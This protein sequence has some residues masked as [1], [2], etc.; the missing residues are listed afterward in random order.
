MSVPDI[1]GLVNTNFSDVEPREMAEAWADRIERHSL[2][3]FDSNLTYAGY[4]DVPV[5]WLFLEDD[6]M[7]SPAVQWEGI[8]VIER[9]SGAKVDVTSIKTGHCPHVMALSDV[10]AWI[11]DL[12]QKCR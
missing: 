12:V 8:E 4:K 3:A 7:L 10:L 11:E 5:S 6:K 1:E 9:A 2:A